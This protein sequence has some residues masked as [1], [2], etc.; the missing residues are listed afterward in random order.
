MIANVGRQLVFGAAHDGKP[1][2]AALAV[3]LLALF[4]G[5]GSAQ[6][7]L[8]HVTNIAD[9][10]DVNP[11]NNVCETAPGNGICTLRAAIRRRTP[12]RVT[13]A[14]DIDAQTHTRRH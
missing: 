14:S 5:W 13:T 1:I 3:L 6:A 2:L 4:L 7:T 9:V 12:T 11:G 8:F 10:A